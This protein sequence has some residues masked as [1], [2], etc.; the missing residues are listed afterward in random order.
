MQGLAWP[1]NK[2]WVINLEFILPV[3]RW[4]DVQSLYLLLNPQVFACAQEIFEH[5]LKS[6]TY[7][8]VFQSLPVSWIVLATLSFLC[9]TLRTGGCCWTL[10][11]SSMPWDS[12]FGFMTLYTARPRLFR[13]T[14]YSKPFFSTTVVTCIACSSLLFKFGFG[15]Y[16]HIY[17]ASDINT[18]HVHVVDFDADLV[19]IVPTELRNT[20]H[21]VGYTGFRFRHRLQ[22]LWWP[23]LAVWQSSVYWSHFSL[24]HA[25]EDHLAG[26]IS[27]LVCVHVLLGPTSSVTC[28]QSPVKQ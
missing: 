24:R 2:I 22:L 28:T 21:R 23:F 8:Y 16:M 18:W 26:S 9:L 17:Y 14:T 20:F 4:N 5:F 27:C 1:N 15:S 7:L 12:S 13:D 10:S 3:A 19:K 25:P 11:R 6:F